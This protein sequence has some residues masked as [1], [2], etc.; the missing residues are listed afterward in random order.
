M[1]TKW[2]TNHDIYNA[3]SCESLYRKARKIRAIFGWELNRSPQQKLKFHAEYA[4]Q[5]EG[6]RERECTYKRREN[7]CYIIIIMLPILKITISLYIRPEC[8]SARR[9]LRKCW[10]FCGVACIHNIPLS[11]W[12]T[13]GIVLYIC[14]VCIHFIWAQKCSNEFTIPL[15]LNSLRE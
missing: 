10:Y 4:N 14:C 1:C 8:A 2:Y 11:S 3:Y 12:Y 9:R 15:Q 13:T 6:E 5:K 7:G